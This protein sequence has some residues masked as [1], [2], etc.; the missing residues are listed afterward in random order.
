MERYDIWLTPTLGTPPPV[1][2]HFEAGRLGGD[3]VMDRFM[4]FLAFT[5]FANM[6]GQPAMTV[7]LAWNAAGLPVGSQF[8]GRYG[9]E[10]TLFRLAGSL[11]QARPWNRRRPTVWAGDGA[12]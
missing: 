11:E 1:L 12:G 9:D 3:A 7:P 4:E 5:T 8:I 2:G 6:T 10:A